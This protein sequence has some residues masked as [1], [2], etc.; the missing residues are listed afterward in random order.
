MA[1]NLTTTI[2]SESKTVEIHRSNPTVIIGERINP[3]GRENLLAELKE[4]KFDIVRS[5]AQKQ[6]EAGAAILDVNAGVPGAD[7]E[8][9]LKEM[10]EILMEVT[11]VPLCIDTADNPALETALSTYKG[12]A[13]INSVNGEEARL[14]SV[15]PLVKEYEAS[16][17]GLCMDD[18]GIPQTP[19]DRFQVAAKII[20]RADKL[21]IPPQNIVI[22]PLA[23]TMG[24][25]HNAGRI[26]IETIELVVEE[27]GVNVTMG[28]SN[29]S[30]G[31]P[32]REHIDSTFIAMAILA[33]M[34]CPITNPL[35]EEVNLAVQAADLVMGR[36]EYG[37]NWIKSYRARQK[38]E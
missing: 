37:M 10:V 28:C 12:K 11:D 31:M 1:E 21:G 13:L 6:V 2:T 3:T 26:A 16:V 19:Q 33:G 8:P 36:D 9:I 23:L 4:G 5:D 18:D 32:D 38:E 30:F 34:T 17:I 27:F 22:D 24:S 7:E 14:E 35:H 20:E 25:D 15:L 29:I